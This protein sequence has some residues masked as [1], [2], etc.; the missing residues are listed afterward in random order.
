MLKKWMLGMLLLSTSL[1]S[2]ATI[3]SA[4]T[5]DMLAGMEV[6]VYFGDGSSD[7]Q[8]WAATGVDSGAAGS[9]D[10]NLSL[11]GDTFGQSTTVG[12]WYLDNLGNFDGIVGL[13]INASYANNYFDIVDSIIGTP[14]SSFGRP[15]YS[16]LGTDISHSFTGLYSAP[17]LYS[18]LE[19]EWEDENY[20]DVSEQLIFG[21]DTDMVRAG[22]DNKPVPEPGT[23]LLF[24][25]SVLA[26]KRFRS[27]KAR[28]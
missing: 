23:L 21:T 6:T 16:N 1:T 11:T 12:V 10:W 28:K 17:D 4:V 18:T 3:I 20:L 5:A 22:I 8:I 9:S 13:D 26:L 27:S 25:T 2:N 24:A 14:D 7:T 19:I 15:F